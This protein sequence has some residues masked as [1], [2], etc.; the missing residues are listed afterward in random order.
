MTSNQIA[1]AQYLAD[2]D[3]KEKSLLFTGRDVATR[4]KQA[5][6]TA[7][8]QAAEERHLGRQ[9]LVAE[10]AQE[11][12]ERANRIRENTDI[13]KVLETQRSNTANESIKR[14]AN[15]ETHRAN[16]AHETEENRSNVAR[17]TETNRA[18]LAKEFETHRSNVANETEKRRSNLANESIGRAQV[19]VGMQQA[20]ASMMNAAAA[21]QNAASNWQSAVWRNEFNYDKLAQ[22]YDLGTRNLS[23]EWDKSIL[24]SATNLGSGLLNLFG[25]VVTK[26]PK[27]GGGSRGRGGMKHARKR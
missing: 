7:L 22:D 6:I 25:D 26:K 2:R 24:G 16:L 12:A 11:E 5:R 4:E 20:Q 13:L 9:D 23:T 17:E 27:A 15:L 14:D 19:G 18:N 8:K 10:A 1:Y 3:F 21:Q